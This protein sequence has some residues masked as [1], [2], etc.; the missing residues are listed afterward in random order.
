MAR[1]SERSNSRLS[2]ASSMGS[3]RASNRDL[4]GTLQAMHCPDAFILN[5]TTSA[6]TLS[7]QLPALTRAT[8]ERMPRFRIPEGEFQINTSALRRAFP[9]F[10]QYG[11]SDEDSIEMGRSVPQVPENQTTLSEEPSED[12]TFEVEDGKRWRVTGTPPL[13]PRPNKANPRAPNES[14]TNLKNNRGVSQKE[15]QDPLAKTADFVSSSGS[16][17]AGKPDRRALADLHARVESDDSI[18]INGD[19]PQTKTTTRNA[20]FSGAQ[21]K[22]VSQDPT[23]SNEFTQEPPR[24]DTTA[25]SAI[26]GTHESFML[27]DLAN[28][29]ELVS[30]VRPD[31]TPLFNRSTKARSRF[32]TPS[33]LRRSQNG[34]NAH[35]PIDGIPP[36][37]NDQALYVSLQFLQDKVATLEKNKKS[38]EDRA[39]EYELEVLQLRSELQDQQNRNVLTKSSG[40]DV[41]QKDSTEW[42]AERTKLEDA[43]ESLEE[44]LDQANRKVSKSETT[45][46]Q[47]KHGSSSAHQQVAQ[48][49]LG[50]VDLRSESQNVQREISG[51]RQ[52][53]RR[54]TKQHEKRIE[55]LMDQE[56]GLRE[57]IERREK[58]VNEMADMAKEL[59]AT[60]NQL[61]TK[62]LAEHGRQSDYSVERQLTN[63]SRPK[64]VDNAES[65][66]S[67]RR[68]VS[69]SQRTDK[70]IDR[71]V[72]ASQVEPSRRAGQEAL[73][74]VQNANE[75][76]EDDLTKRDSFLSFMDGDEVA[77]LKR[78]LD[79]DKARLTDVVPTVAGVAQGTTAGTSTLPR[80][81]SLKVSKQ[82]GRAQHVQYDDEVTGP[83]IR[84]DD[85]MTTEIDI[86]GPNETT[87]DLTHQSMASKGSNRR[88]STAFAADDMTSAFILPDITLS[89][90]GIAVQKKQAATANGFGKGA[91]TAVPRPIPVSERLPVHLPGEE[92]PTLR[93]AQPPALALATVLK[94]LEDELAHLRSE[95][96]IQEA[97]YHSHDP[98]LSKRERK[99]VYARMQKLLAT[100]EARSDRIYAL[101]DVLEGQKANGMTM[102]EDEVE[103][104][105]QQVGVDATVLR[106]GAAK[107]A[108]KKTGLQLEGGDDLGDSLSEASG[109]DQDDYDAPWDGIDPTR[110]M[111]SLGS[112]GPYRR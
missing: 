54:M 1:Q 80:K 5:L 40:F 47:L 61:S 65:I 26:N 70:G 108:D 53:L 95:L 75:W 112:I 44:R 93:P 87:K 35:V 11:S 16:S 60:R 96:A 55:K 84:D 15:N 39:D 25:T 13:R 102:Q 69:R 37:V 22:T 101:Y 52:Q 72:S 81:S 14:S 58:A 56:Q 106:E 83:V 36:A 30:G 21:N 19:R 105:L 29:T 76:S 88:R 20:R 71:R 94:A 64:S 63:L 4:G 99:A 91:K 78:V 66:R 109:D 100:A 18:S 57:K 24:R 45:I 59:W 74:Q 89:E 110:T 90:A 12:M 50:S 98:A 23:V 82:G 51:L 49:Q 42:E 67:G 3:G 9:D 73:H 2:D 31:G 46:K 86:T 32:A 38:V 7:Q 85:P 8:P 27:P 92:E 111:E 34:K 10:S 33:S 41:H 107:A 97:H 17:K 48:A 6:E 62:A 79:Q 43:I 68:S 77:K 104:T 28:I 103:L